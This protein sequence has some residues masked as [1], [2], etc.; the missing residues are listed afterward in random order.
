MSSIKAY[1]EHLRLDDERAEAGPTF[2]YHHPKVPGVG[3]PSWSAATMDL[4]ATTPL[5]DIGRLNL[6]AW[7]ADR[8]LRDVIS[9]RPK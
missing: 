6:I 5:S 4:P 1:P 3:W 7:R 9:R 2:R 8:E